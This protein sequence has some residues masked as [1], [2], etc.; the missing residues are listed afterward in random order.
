MAPKPISGKGLKGSDELSLEH[1]KTLE[2]CSS[3]DGPRRL[4]EQWS[5]S[6]I[7][8]LVAR[9]SN[10]NKSI[11][12]ISFHLGGTLFE[13]E[14]LK[15]NCSK[16][17]N[18]SENLSM[19]IPCLDT[20]I[21]SFPNGGLTSELVD[22]SKFRVNWYK[23]GVIMAP[24]NRAETGI[25]GFCLRFH[26]T[27]KQSLVSGTWATLA[28]ILYP[29]PKAMLLEGHPLSTNA[30][31][32]GFR[33]FS[34][35]V[36]Q[37]GFNSAKRFK[38]LSWGSPILPACIP[39]GDWDDLPFCPSTAELKTKM[40]ATLRNVALPDTRKSPAELK[41]AWEDL[42]ATGAGGLKN[43]ASGLKWIWP[44]PSAKSAPAP[45]GRP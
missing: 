18:V 40:A 11:E 26:A 12:N 10:D 14:D 5:G 35:D 24:E 25:T 34:S 32:P 23:D 41:K 8:F 29:L 38:D 43:T 36:F 31:F 7:G 45:Q 33:L 9:L 6:I 13:E 42:K 17:W 37:I 16:F 44:L 15:A 1:W 20:S 21:F 3:S 19:A 39:G 4:Q 2:V 27:P 22:S 30:N 28:L